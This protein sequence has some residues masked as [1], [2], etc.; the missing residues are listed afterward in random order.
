MFRILVVGYSCDWRKRVSDALGVKYELVVCC[1]EI[2]AYS[3][4]EVD[5]MYF[6]LYIFSNYRVTDGG[7]GLKLLSEARTLD[8]PDNTPTIIFSDSVDEAGVQRISEL[9][10]IWIDVDNPNAIAAL[11]HTVSELLELA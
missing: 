2:A 8:D 5:K 4:L 6:D 3:K 1:D 7:I 9:D 10:G 11:K